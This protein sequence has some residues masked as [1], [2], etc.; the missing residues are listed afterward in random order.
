MPANLKTLHA[1]LF[2]LQPVLKYH[3]FFLFDFLL[4]CISSVNTIAMAS[5]IAVSK[6]GLSIP[7]S[8]PMPS[9][10]QLLP[11]KLLLFQAH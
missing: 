2:S 8:N 11:T 5:G 10:L 6:E 7:V 9:R 1:T 3:N 4:D